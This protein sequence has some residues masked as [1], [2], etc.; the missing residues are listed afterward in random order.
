MW[1]M[2]ML[3]DFIDQRDNIYS[4]NG[5]QGFLIL[6]KDQFTK[7]PGQSYNTEYILWDIPRCE[8]Y[9]NLRSNKK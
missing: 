6:N 8:F 5:T 4:R 7:Y 3:L 2:L 1:L 9:R